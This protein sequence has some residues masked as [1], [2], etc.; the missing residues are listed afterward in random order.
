MGIEAAPLGLD[1]FWPA[2]STAHTALRIAMTFSRD[3][4]SRDKGPARRDMGAGLG[5]VSDA[6]ANS[7]E[8]GDD[9]ER[10]FVR[11]REPQ[12]TV[13]EWTVLAPA[14]HGLTLDPPHLP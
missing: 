6:Q 4:F 12:R 5:E 7:L 8:A 13:G 2:C 9:F 1:F 11:R 3:T 10:L 14:A